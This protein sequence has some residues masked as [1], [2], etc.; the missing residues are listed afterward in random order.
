MAEGRAE[1]ILRDDPNFYQMPFCAFYLDG[2]GGATGPLIAMI[3]AIFA[4]TRR[5]V[6][7]RLPRLAVGFTLTSACASGCPLSVREEQAT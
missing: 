6:M 2:C 3:D 7:R 4:E 5:A 1:D